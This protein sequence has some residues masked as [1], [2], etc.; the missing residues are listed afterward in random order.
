MTT[1]K[2]ISE[3]EIEEWFISEETTGELFP[4]EQKKTLEEKYAESQLRVIRTSLDF[5][6]YHLKQ[7]LEDK[8]YINAS[9]NYQRRHRWD[10]KK[11]SQLIES[12]LMNIPVPSVFLYENNYNQY[13]IMDGRQRIDTLRS[14]FNN[15]F[16]LKGLEFW[17]ELEG[18]RFRDLPN[19]IQRGLS[20]RT[21]N[22][23]VLLAETSK[24]SESSIDIRKILFKRLNTGGIQLN[25]QELRNALYPGDFN[26][27]MLDLSRTNPFTDIW[28]IPPKLSNEDEE[29]STE[30]L[31]NSLYK[32]MADCEL[33]LRFFA[34]K[35]MVLEDLGGSL[36]SILDK[37][38]QKYQHLSPETI[39]DF[40]T[41]FQICILG[42]HD[43]FGEHTFVVPSTGR[44]SRPLYDA[45]MVAYSRISKTQ[46][47][48]P[49]RIKDKLSNYADDPEKYEI[50]IGRGNTPDSIKERVT[51]AEKI[52]SL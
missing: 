8:D 30:L 43:I 39:S 49:D 2:R 9:P 38:C 11:R 19:I 51:L 13:E 5:T 17:S 40:E 28:G 4:A 33:V 48:S 20:R 24:A 16:P 10:I 14:F 3:N 46:L 29:P 36:R 1:N 42:L 50:L 27:L 18:K 25:A 26:N 35:R 47:D 37:T 12:F 45:L 21:L 32:S 44:L 7:S 31:K 41:E 52:L 34:I 23:I 6:L 22:A 15:E